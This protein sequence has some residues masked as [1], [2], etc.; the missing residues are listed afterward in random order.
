ML[1]ENEAVFKFG[2]R[3]GNVNMRRELIFLM[4]LQLDMNVAGRDDRSSLVHD[5]GT[6][7]K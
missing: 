7:L 5:T 6:I 2:E 1:I 4:K 3:G